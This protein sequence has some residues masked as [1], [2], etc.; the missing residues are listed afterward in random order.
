M[1]QENKILYWLMTFRR[2]LHLKS[3]SAVTKKLECWG[4]GEQM[5]NS[6]SKAVFTLSYRKV[7]V[8]VSVWVAFCAVPWS[9]GTCGC[10]VHQICWGSSEDLLQSCTKHKRSDL[11]VNGPQ[12]SDLK[13]EVFHVCHR[14]GITRGSASYMLTRSRHLLE[15]G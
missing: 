8:R 10:I 1:K 2:C 4:A 7:V 5:I 6:S 11:C 14:Y 3:I 13:T 9:Y 12:C 15:W